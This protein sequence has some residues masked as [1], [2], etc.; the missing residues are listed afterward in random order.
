MRSPPGFVYGLAYVEALLA[1]VLVAVLL[2]PALEALS[3]GLLNQ[4]G[5][6]TLTN[7]DTALRNKLEEVQARPYSALLAET[8]AADGNTATSVSPTFSDPEGP[9]RRIVTI[10]RTNG[11]DVAT[12]DTG[13]LLIRVKWEDNRPAAALVSLKSKWL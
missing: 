5:G 1:A 2:A 3:T 11:S 10:Y 8:N 12:A 4:T 7:P 9:D 6:A 13:L